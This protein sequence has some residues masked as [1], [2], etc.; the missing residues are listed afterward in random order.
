MSLYSDAKSPHCV[1]FQSKNIWQL[2][3]LLLGISALLRTAERF[4]YM[5]LHWD[6]M[7]QWKTDDWLYW[8]L[9]NLVSIAFAFLFLRHLSKRYNRPLMLASFAL[10][11]IG[12]ISYFLILVNSVVRFPRPFPLIAD[13]CSLL[14]M[15]GSPLSCILGPFMETSRTASRIYD[16]YVVSADY[17][18]KSIFLAICIGKYPQYPERRG[19]AQTQRQGLGKAAHA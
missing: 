4:I 7:S 6:E 14:G 12:T 5:G 9:L 1:R 8:G 18:V 17:L 13:W 10:T 2:G 16:L 15:S 19:A 11:W 3:F